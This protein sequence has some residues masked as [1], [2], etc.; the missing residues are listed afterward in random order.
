LI[1]GQTATM[2]GRGDH[3]PLPL[4]GVAGRDIEAEHA[5][6]T[7]T[8][9]GRFAIEDN[10]SRIGTLV[11]G[12]PIHGAAGLADGDLIRLG[13]NILRFSLR[14]GR[15]ERAVA[16][17]VGAKPSAAMPLPPPPPGGKPQSP[18][19]APN[20]PASAIP[21][22]PPSQSGGRIPPPPPPPRRQL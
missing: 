15:G 6:I 1:L 20:V 18:L 16:P 13:S 21:A 9:D 19:P 4:L 2:L 14:S 11:N 5:R 22:K 8:P 10:H 17:P 12:K 3:L 7:R